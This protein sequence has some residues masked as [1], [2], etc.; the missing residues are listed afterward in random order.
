M[1]KIDGAEKKHPLHLFLPILYK[2]SELCSGSNLWDRVELVEV[3]AAKQRM[4]E[5]PNRTWGIKKA[6]RKSAWMSGDWS[7]PF[8]LWRVIGKP[9][10]ARKLSKY[11]TY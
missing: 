7:F 1:S 9:G 11:L 4:S 8:P 5:S 3:S 6:D 10:Q 2:M